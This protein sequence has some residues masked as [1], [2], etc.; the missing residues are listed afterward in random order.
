MSKE[1]VDVLSKYDTTHVF[2]LDAFERV[3][4][5]TQFN[6]ALLKRAS[7]ISTS[8]AC[9][10]AYITHLSFFANGHP[11]YGIPTYHT[12]PQKAS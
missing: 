5:A 11:Y 7:L 9:F 8:T 6:K 10:V 12:M 3:F 1:I 4:K 2:T